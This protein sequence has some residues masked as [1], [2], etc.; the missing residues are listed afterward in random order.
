MVSEEYSTIQKQYNDLVTENDEL[1]SKNRELEKIKNELI[2]NVQQLD[3]ALKRSENIISEIEGDFELAKNDVD[4]LAQEVA[5]LQ[6]ENKSLIEHGSSKIKGSEDQITRLNSELMKMKEDYLNL[7]NESS[8][9]IEKLRQELNL[10]VGSQ[11][12]LNLARGELAATQA[13]LRVSERERQKAVSELQDLQGALKRLTEEMERLEGDSKAKTQQLKNTMEQSK[14]QAIEYIKE[15]MNQQIETLMRKVRSLEDVIQDQTS[16]IARLEEKESSMITS[17]TNSSSS[18]LS[19]AKSGSLPASPR[20]ANS[21]NH[22]MIDRAI[23]TKLIVT[24]FARGSIGGSQA[25]REVLEM[26]SKI[27]EFTTEERKVV[28]LEKDENNTAAQGVINAGLGLLMGKQG[29][30][31]AKENAKKSAKIV[32]EKSFEELFAQFVSGE[33]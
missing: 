24:Y 13:D 15:D 32:E 19:D 1:K 30:Q 10:Y 4:T 26:M 14:A 16:K 8:Q 7:L 21:L 23:A 18:S 6:E 22:A 29:L 2:M 5:R 33:L 17:S 11:Q 28:G 25:Q 12:E 20:A 27:L 9:T 31:L 3:A